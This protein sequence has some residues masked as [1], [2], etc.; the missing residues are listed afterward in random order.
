MKR[1]LKWF[2]IAVL[3]I[4]A[5]NV[6]IKLSQGQGDR[7]KPARMSIEDWHIRQYLSVK[8]YFAENLKDPDSVK[9]KPML[10]VNPYFNFGPDIGGDV[11]GYYNAKN[12]F[13]GYGGWQ[14]FVQVGKENIVY[15]SGTQGFERAW[16]KHCRGLSGYTR[17][18]AVGRIP[19]TY[20]N[21]SGNDLELC[22]RRWFSAS[23]K[24]V[25]TA[26]FPKLI[27]ACRG[28]DK[29]GSVADVK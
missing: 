18:K 15:T 28:G 11:C 27:I 24:D 26:L 14:P 19:L 7:A 12:S 17:S 23:M 5:V 1:I 6:G 16:A 3:L 13:G 2:G 21:A 25:G 8:R 20:G 4:T 22:V 9:F 29:C 10:V